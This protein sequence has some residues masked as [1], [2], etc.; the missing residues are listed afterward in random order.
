MDKLQDAMDVKLMKRS[1]KWGMGILIVGGLLVFQL[2]H[3]LAK[4]GNDVT[5][6]GGGI[7]WSFTT[8]VTGGYADIHNPKSLMGRLLTVLLVITGMILVGVF[9]ATLTSLY[10]GE[11]SE[12]MQQMQETMTDRLDQMERTIAELSDQMPKSGDK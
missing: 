10:V 3:N 11:E 5:T 7:W 2:E 8:I 12:E 9:T 1:L 6:V 4:E